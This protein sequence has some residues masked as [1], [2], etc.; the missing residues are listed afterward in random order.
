MKLCRLLVSRISLTKAEAIARNAEESL[1]WSQRPT[2]HWLPKP[3]RSIFSLSTRSLHAIL[4]WNCFGL[5][6][7]KCGRKSNLIRILCEISA[8]TYSILLKEK[9]NSTNSFKVQKKLSPLLSLRIWRYLE[10]CPDRA[11]W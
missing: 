5:R 10:S 3:L 9:D 6:S 4:C 1:V 11:T 8:I 2:L 7:V